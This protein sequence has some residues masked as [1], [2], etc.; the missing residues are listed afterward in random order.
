MEIVKIPR[1]KKQEYDRVIKENHVCRIA[2]HGSEYPYIAPFMYVFDG[3]Y[4]HFLSTKYGK[5]IDLFHSE[6]AVAVEMERYAPDLSAYTFVTLQGR[7]EEVADQ[8]TKRTIKESFATMIKERALSANIMAALGHDPK[9]P[10]DALVREDRTM[11]WRLTN[12]REIVAL[13]NP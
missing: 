11:V 3:R 5:K 1:M 4:I 2:F 12:V 6:P 10:P 7:R 9:D 8:K 13:K